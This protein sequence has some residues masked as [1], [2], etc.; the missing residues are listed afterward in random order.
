MI[1]LKTTV[2]WEVVPCSFILVDRRFRGAYNLHLQALCK[3]VIWNVCQFLR[4]CTAQHLKRRSSSHS[5]KWQREISYGSPSLFLYFKIS[6]ARGKIYLDVAFLC[7]WGRAVLY[8]G[9]NT[10]DDQTLLRPS[11]VSQPRKPESAFPLPWKSQIVYD[12]DFNPEGN[13]HNFNVPRPR[14]TYIHV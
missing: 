7:V 11:A 10:C 2:F 1:S 3:A 14:V 4:G 6:K 8:V 13:R 12:I 5:P 9:I